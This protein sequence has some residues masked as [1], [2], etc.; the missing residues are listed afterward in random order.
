MTTA[1]FSAAAD[2]AHALMVRHAGPEV[3]RLASR[4]TLTAE[5]RESQ[6]PF[7][8]LSLLGPPPSASFADAVGTWLAQHLDEPFDLAR[9]AREFHVSTRSLLRRFSQEAG[10][11]PLQY[12]Q[13]LRVE[14]AKQLLESTDLRLYEIARQVGYADQAAFRKVFG[15][16]TDT[17]PS[18]YR[19]RFQAMVTD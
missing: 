18:S 19:Q 13:R 7:V 14:R 1:A 3:T 8:E 12:V 10:T 15:A 11:S 2:L 6:T 17:T 5:R 16:H 4:V 9:V